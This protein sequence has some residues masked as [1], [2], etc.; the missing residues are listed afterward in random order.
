[1][2]TAPLPAEPKQERAVL[3]RTT[4]LDAAV[5]ELIDVG[6]ARLTTLAVAQRAGISRG[7]QQRYFPHKHVLVVE[8]VRRL[9]FR[10]QAELRRRVEELPDD[11]ARVEGALDVA[12]DLYGGQ[13]FAA[14]LELSFAARTE[15]DLAAIVGEQEQLIGRSLADLPHELFP[16]EVRELPNVD[17]WWATALATARGLAMLRFLGYSRKAID[18]QWDYART[19]LLG[20]LEEDHDN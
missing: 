2:S 12:F 16:A 19:G 11:H 4:L 17:R 15:P 18:A 9:A 6:Y 10:G 1:M 8:A 20:M 13:L 3:T 5:D 14:I 7:A